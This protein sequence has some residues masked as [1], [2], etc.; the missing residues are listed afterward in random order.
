[1][2]LTDGPRYELGAAPSTRKTRDDRC[3]AGRDGPDGP[4]ALA[5]HVGCGAVV[6]VRHM[7]ER[8]HILEE[9][10]RGLVMVPQADIVI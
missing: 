5:V 6:R 1:M 9:T 3:L 4:P 8:E 10:G 2:R 7:C